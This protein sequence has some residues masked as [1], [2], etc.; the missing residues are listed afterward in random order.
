MPEDGGSN[1]DGASE[2]HGEQ[3]AEVQGTGWAAGRSQNSGTAMPL[4]GRGGGILRL[5]ACECL[6]LG[7]E[8][9]QGPASEEPWGQVMDS[10]D[11]MGEDEAVGEHGWAGAS[12]SPW[13]PPR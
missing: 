8:E 11:D 9:S 4:A 7:W 13:A 6:G 3:G 12:P 1:K 5:P 2:G 10:W